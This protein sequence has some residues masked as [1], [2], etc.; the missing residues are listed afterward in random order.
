MRAQQ[1]RFWRCIEHGAIADA[2]PGEQL[3]IHQLTS[4]NTS[5]KPHGRNLNGLTNPVAGTR[6]AYRHSSN[7]TLMAAS[8]LHADQ[9]AEKG[10]SMQ[11]SKYSTACWQIAH[12]TSQPLILGAGQ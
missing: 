4:T 11:P 6:R 5:S 10:D 3:Q 2:M 9:L 12:S 1:H 7:L 8:A